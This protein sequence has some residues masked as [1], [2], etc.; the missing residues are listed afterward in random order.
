MAE[1]YSFHSLLP[2]FSV[3]ILPLLPCS[4]SSPLL[5][6]RPSGVP[7]REGVTE[8]KGVEEAKEAND[9]HHPTPPQRFKADLNSWTC[10]PGGPKRTLSG[11][12]GVA[13]TESPGSSG[14]MT[15]LWWSSPSLFPQR[16]PG[17][18]RDQALSGRGEQEG[19]SDERAK[20]K[21]Q[22]RLKA[23]GL[24]CVSQAPA[25][26]HVLSRNL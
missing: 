23:P 9:H 13:G 5:W 26:T 16:L 19:T 14:E 3:S 10:S 22:E 1:P 7:V 20:H 2:P 18:G 12:G 11:R 25:E 24:M 8:V 15:T 6:V 4:A 17:G 21:G